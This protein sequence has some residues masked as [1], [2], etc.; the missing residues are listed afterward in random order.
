MWKNHVMA[1][2]KRSGLGRAK[3][4]SGSC[5]PRILNASHSP[6]GAFLSSIRVLPQRTQTALIKVASD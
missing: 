1:R 3:D 5:R 6:V 4:L 2:R